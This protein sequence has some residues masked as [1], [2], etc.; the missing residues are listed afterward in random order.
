MLYL[1]VSVVSVFD[2]GG[3]SGEFERMFGLTR[4]VCGKLTGRKST[5]EDVA[6]NCDKGRDGKKDLKTVGG[7]DER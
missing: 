7:F 6:G 4:L 3:Y 2:G 5:S 1:I